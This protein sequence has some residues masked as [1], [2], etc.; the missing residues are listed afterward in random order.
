MCVFTLE[1]VS[2]LCDGHLPNM[3]HH[4]FNYALEPVALLNPGLPCFF[5]YHMYHKHFNY[6]LEP[7]ALSNPGLPWGG[8]LSVPLASF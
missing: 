5:M 8:G 3:Y 7:A 2:L 6:A 4:H 1:L